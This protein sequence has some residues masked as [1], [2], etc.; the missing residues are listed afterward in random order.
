MGMGSGLSARG[1]SGLTDNY[2]AKPSTSPIRCRLFVDMRLKRCTAKGL[3]NR[4]PLSIARP[5]DLK[6][7][8]LIAEASQCYY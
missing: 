4:Q 5:E 3:F 6:R 7:L 8:H 2:A 1:P